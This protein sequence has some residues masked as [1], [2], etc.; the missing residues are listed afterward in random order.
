MA[1][2]RFTSFHSVVASLL[3]SICSMQ[4][5][6]ELAKYAAFFFKS[7][8][9]CM[10]FQSAVEQLEN[11]PIDAR[12]STW[13]QSHQQAPA[14]A[15]TQQSTRCKRPSTWRSRNR[16]RSLRSVLPRKLSSTPP[17]SVLRTKS[18]CG[19]RSRCSHVY[20]VA[21]TSP[22]STVSDRPLARRCLRIS[23]W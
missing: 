16:Q 17:N 4:T 3:S 2:Q 5:S 12:R 13:P 22:R 9:V 8:L 7:L 10:N 14:A 6:K 11:F 15:Q 20:P 19:Q 1:L 21:F 18:S 23:R